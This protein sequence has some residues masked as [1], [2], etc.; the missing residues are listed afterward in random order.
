MTTFCDILHLDDYLTESDKAQ[1]QEAGSQTEPVMA[2]YERLIKEHNLQPKRGDIVTSD[3]SRVHNRDRY[4]WDGDKLWDLDY[5]YSDDGHIPKN[6]AILEAPDNFEPDAWEKALS[7]SGA[8]FNITPH[9]SQIF[10]SLELFEAEYDMDIYSCIFQID[11]RKYML[12]FSIE[13]E[14]ES[15]IEDAKDFLNA[16]NKKGVIEV[17][18]DLNAC[19]DNPNVVYIE[20]V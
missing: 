3:G 12:Y 1:I 14:S 20:R 9:F 16:L 11:G 5:T 7:M 10:E 18:S 15:V 8:F 13:E 6:F 17:D 4:F 19:Y 2:I